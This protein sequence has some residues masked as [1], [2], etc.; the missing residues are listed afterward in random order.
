[1]RMRY[2]GFWIV[3]G[4]LGVAS[5]ATAVPQA[6][7]QRFFYSG[8]GRL[9]LVSAKNGLS[10]SGVYRRPG[11][12]YDPAALRTIQRVFDAPPDDPVALLSLRLIEFMDYLEDHLHPGARIEIS[13]GWRSPEYNT[14]LR[15]AGGLAA[16]ASLHQYG[17]A[18]DLR[19][20]GV[21]A[22]KL[23][24]YVRK[25]GFGGAGYYHGALVHV[26][27]G[28]AR[29]W[30][31][32]STG[33]GTDISIENKLIGLTADY[34]RYRPAETVVLRFTRMTAFPV[35]VSPDFVLE[36]V[37]PQG[38]IAETRN[39]RPVFQA[40][41][42]DPCPQWSGIDQ[43]MNITFALPGDLQPGRYQIRATFCDRQWEAMPAAAV[44]P[45]FEVQD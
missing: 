16:S 25:L 10:F 12:Q 9:H 21:G 15:E 5:A 4:W 22:R 28:P 13:S 18:A 32:T 41:A 6:S 3:L 29:F 38:M 40:A 39:V 1:M 24:H 20:E 34:D 35:G 42:T 17:M 7:G 27:V 26:D 2:I 44:T 36:R 11:G 23:W 31:E 33:V 45:V 8:N 30:D 37:S 43:M 14:R 19:I